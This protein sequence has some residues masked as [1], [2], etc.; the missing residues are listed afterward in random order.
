MDAALWTSQ[1]DQP[2]TLVIGNHA[3]LHDGA[4]PAGC[5][6]LGFGSN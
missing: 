3:M 5:N 2:K 1:D 6:P 4:L